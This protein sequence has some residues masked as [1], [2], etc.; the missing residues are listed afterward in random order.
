MLVATLVNLI[1]AAGAEPL[2][3]K[4]GTLLLTVPLI[5]GVGLR[6]PRA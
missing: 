6:R 3:Y 4:L 1:L 2:W 5:L